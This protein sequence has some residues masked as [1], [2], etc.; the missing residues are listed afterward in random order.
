MSHG[1]AAASLLMCGAFLLVGCKHPPVALGQDVK[2]VC[3]EDDDLH[4]KEDRTTFQFGRWIVPN[5]FRLKNVR[6]VD[7]PWNDARNLQRLDCDGKKYTWTELQAEDS[8]YRC[9]RVGAP[10][11]AATAELPAATTGEDSGL[12][13][14]CK[15]TCNEKDPYSRLQGYVNLHRAGPSRPMVS[16]CVQLYDIAASDGRKAGVLMLLYHKDVGGNAHAGY[17]HGEEQ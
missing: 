1:K 7:V 3:I 13:D 8:D 5:R 4:L 9:V 14:P 17:A 10:E 11:P 16:H 6:E 12:P 2:V 15:S